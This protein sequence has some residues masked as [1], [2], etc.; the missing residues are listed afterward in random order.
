[1]PLQNLKYLIKKLWSKTEYRRAIFEDQTHAIA[2][3][4]KVGKQ[5]LTTKILVSFIPV[6][7]LPKKSVGKHS[8]I[9]KKIDQST[10][11]RKKG[12]DFSHF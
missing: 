7:N 5:K 6:F 10:D 12:T 1:M 3:F 11:F 2:N 8:L 9:K 4:F